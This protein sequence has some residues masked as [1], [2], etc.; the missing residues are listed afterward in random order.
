MVGWPG[1]KRVEYW[2][3][4]DPGTKGKLGGR[5][6]GL[7]ARPT[8]SRASSIR[9]RRTGAAGCPTACCRRTCG[10]S[11]RDGRPK[12]WPLR[13]SIAHWSL[14]LA[15]L[16]AGRLR[17]PRADGGRNGFAQPEPRPYP[18][19]G[20]EPGP[21]QAADRHGLIASRP[22][23]GRTKHSSPDGVDHV[24]R[25]PP[26]PSPWRRP[27]MAAVLG[28]IATIPASAEDRKAAR[29]E[30]SPTQRMAPDRLRATHEDAQRIR[31]SRR[32]LPPLPGLHDYRAI[33][34]ATPRTRRTRGGRGRRCWPRRSGPAS[35]PSS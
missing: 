20:A 27:A 22:N 3:R 10:A 31:Q 23:R 15:E 1:L 5:R 8:G 13:F 25:E 32:R 2:L 33:L 30:Y 14:T 19:V 18:E 6:P 16:K 24:R 4:P 12:E 29:P 28:M 35:T 11:T 9:R 21:V 7:G 17:V 26:R 34:H